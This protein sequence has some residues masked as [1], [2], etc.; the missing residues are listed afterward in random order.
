VNLKHLS[1]AA[2]EKK[3]RSLRTL[4]RRE[5]I[6]TENGRRAAVRIPPDIVKRILK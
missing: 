5:L 1:R 2:A 6:N 3:E 4:I